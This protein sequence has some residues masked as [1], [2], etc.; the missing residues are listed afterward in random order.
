MQEGVDRRKLIEEKIREAEGK[1]VTSLA[2]I[3]E[4]VKDFLVHVK[5]YAEEEIET[6]KEFEIAVGDMKA[7]VSVDY[8]LKLGERRF[9]A[10]KCS[11]GALE[12]RE[13][14]LLSFARVV[15]SCQMAFAVVTDGYRA[16]ILDGVSGRLVAE[17]LASMPARAQADEILASVKP[18]PCPVERMEREK[19]I[20]LAFDAIKCTEESCE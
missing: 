17:D 2:L 5:G 10:V 20:L 3:R 9:A 1:A 16:R 19:R 7:A 12:S 4:A 18:A 6:D 14:H 8:I 13:R 11:P 15:D